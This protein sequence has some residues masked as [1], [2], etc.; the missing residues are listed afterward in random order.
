[1]A[2]R[3]DGKVVVVTGAGGGLG[4]AY[5]LAFAERGASVVV[6]DLGGSFKG[7]GADT[8]PAVKVVDE[9]KAKGGKAVP[10]F[11]SVENGEN[12]IKT[13][14][15]NFGRVDILINNAGILRDV[16]FGRMSDS[17][18]D[19]IYKVHVL[20]AYKTTRAAWNYMREQKYGRII[21]TSSSSGIYGNAGQVN[22]ACA[23]LGLVGFSNAL[24]I[25]GSRYNIN[26]NAIAP[27]AGSRMTQTVLSE[28]MVNALKP[29]F[30][31]PFVL[32]LC[33]ESCAETGGLFEVGG[34][35][36]AKV[37]WLRAKG[38]LFSLSKPIVPEEVVKEWSK[39]TD[40]ENG[41]SPATQQDA[42]MVIYENL[43][44]FS[45]SSEAEPSAPTPKSSLKAA[46]VFDKLAQ[47][48][49]SN[50]EVIK[51]IGCIY[52]WNITDGK[53][54]KGSWIMDLK[55][56]SGNIQQGTAEKADT[57]FTLSDDDFLALIDGSL[58]PQQAFL[59]KK[60][61]ITGNLMLSQKLSILLKANPKAKL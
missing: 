13:A 42:G 55:N 41:S 58:N 30:V 23:K 49:K 2:L 18:W 6:N 21:F 36:C 59:K 52:Q 19:L 39:V 44:T 38:A 61:K 54:V 10:N 45:P 56:G 7:E 11:D 16:T 25:E 22:Y 31:A 28:E 34:G 9:I 14:I 37:R 4:R 24:A 8:R 43:G 26:V 29:E 15:D 57:T 51:K 47:L 33:H 3:F 1:M 40:F 48:L 32:T 27:T 12:I 53:E 50:P 60:L 46:E 35:F 20:G 17:D 5:A